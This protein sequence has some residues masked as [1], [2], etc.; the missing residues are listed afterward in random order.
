[1]TLTKTILLAAAFSVAGCLSAASAMPA[2]PLS[3][4]N[5]MTHQA[6]VVCDGFGR[7]YR[8]RPR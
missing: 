5:E 4:E 1:M 8:T 6:R 2:A 3:I 7:C